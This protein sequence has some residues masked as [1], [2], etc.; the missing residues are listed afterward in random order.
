MRVTVCEYLSW[1]CLVQVYHW[2]KSHQR[3]AYPSTLYVTLKSIVPPD[4]IEPSLRAMFPL[5]QASRLFLTGVCGGCVYVTGVYVWCMCVTSVCGVCMSVSL[6]WVWCMCV[7]GV[8][9]C[10]CVIGIW[11]MCVCGVCVSLVCVCVVY[12]SVSLLCVCGVCVTGVCIRVC[13]DG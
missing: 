1:F 10:L 11:C 12:V 3:T 8:C 2:W 9:V 4:N 7:T 13:V 6:V 5:Q